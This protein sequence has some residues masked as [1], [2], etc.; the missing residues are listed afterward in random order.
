MTEIN[1][2]LWLAFFGKLGP[3]LAAD[4]GDTLAAL[5]AV[6]GV[7]DLPSPASCLN[8]QLARFSFP[9][10]RFTVRCFYFRRRRQGRNRAC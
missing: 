3:A 2:L 8:Q 7:K 4:E 5:V 1:W 10:R 9:C 6:V